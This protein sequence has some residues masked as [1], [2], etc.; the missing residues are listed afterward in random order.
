TGHTAQLTRYSNFSGTLN[1]RASIQITNAGVENLTVL[2]GGD[3]GIRYESYAYCWAKNVEVTQWV[4]EGISVDNSFR[5]EIRDSYL[6]TGSWPEPGG[7]GYAISLAHGSSEALIENN[8]ILDNCKDMVFRS[9]GSG[10]VVGYNY[11]DDVWDFDSPIWQEVALNASHM[12]GPHHVL[13]EGN[14]AANF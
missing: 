4:G 2:G 10:T 8:I 5:I 11:V 1:D 6:H 14:Y 9:S 3:G 7:A 12:A 13:F